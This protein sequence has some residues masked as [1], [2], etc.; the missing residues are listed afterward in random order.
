MPNRLADQT[1]PY[2]LQ[3]ADNPV[4]WWPWGADAFT[5]ATERGVPVLLSVGYAACHWCHVMAHESFEDAT[6]AAVMNEHFVNIKVDREERPDVDAV[7][8]D[9]TVA[10][11]GH[12]GWPM[13]V[14]LTP[15]G[16][17]F[18]AGTYFP[19]TPRAG[20]GS[21]RQLLEAVAS[22][23]RTRRD[24]VTAS[25]AD[26]VRQ[27]SAAAD[28]AGGPPATLTA[29]LLA[30][31]VE[32]AGRTFDQA[33]GGFGTAPKFPPSALLEMLL[34][35][36]ARTGDGASLRMVVS[37]CERMARGGIYDQLA[38]GF[39]RYSVDATWTV[40][41]FEKMLYDNAQLLRVYLHLWRATGSALAQ[42]VTR[43]TA[44]FLLS[45][46]RTAQGGFASALDADT[47]LPAGQGVDRAHGVE[48]APVRTAWRVPPMSGR[49]VSLSTSSAR[50]TAAGPRICSASPWQGRSSTGRPFLRWPWTR[51]I[52]RGSTGC[53]PDSR[54]PGR[55]GP[56]RAV[57]TRLSPP[58][59]V[60]RSPRWPRPARCWRSRPG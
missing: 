18:Y 13:T 3:H 40:P 24:E 44:S 27:I 41:H 54:R 29:E 9:V 35:H 39:A 12:G 8:M 21:F 53:G 33:N 25:G 7:Y 28:A 11:T 32:Q 60:W 34:R 14:F 20:M 10:L 52:I 56:S 23:W 47:V 59:T 1:S 58:G 36:S 4:D 2:L 5:E 31:A 45:D 30:A 43:E 38:G 16:E 51:M 19:P 57:T 15:A 42:R 17:P 50:R 49:R 48:G 46:L 6:T 37:T 22:A 55:A 26:I